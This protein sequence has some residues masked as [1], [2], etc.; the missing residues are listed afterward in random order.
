MK[1]WRV[2]IYDIEEAYVR[3]S[4][5]KVNFTNQTRKKYNISDMWSWLSIQKLKCLPGYLNESP[6]AMVGSTSW[7]RISLG[8][9]RTDEVDAFFIPKV[10]HLS[11]RIFMFDQVHQWDMWL[12]SSWFSF[13]RLVIATSSM[14]WH[15]W[16]EER[17][18]MEK[19]IWLIFWAEI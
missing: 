3:M 9:Y 7:F 1:L 18:L 16:T 13:S 12:S 14:N 8:K 6:L 17:D 2:Q 5:K 10:D 15:Q 19:P 11:T 4:R